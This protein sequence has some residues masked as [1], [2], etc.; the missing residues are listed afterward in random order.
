MITHAE[1][2][3]QDEFAK[4]GAA[5]SPE[6]LERMRRVAKLAEAVAPTRPHAGIESQAANLMVGPFVAM[7][8]RTRDILSGKA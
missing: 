3:E 6:E 8:D 5:L 4:L 2:E 7:L 1:H